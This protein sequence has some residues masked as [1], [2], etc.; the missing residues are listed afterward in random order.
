[1]TYQNIEPGVKYPEEKSNVFL[2]RLSSL[3]GA[4]CRSKRN[5]CAQPSSLE[6]QNIDTLFNEEYV[7]ADKSDGLRYIL[8]LDQINNKNY[9]FLI[10]RKLDFYQVPVAGGKNFFAGSVFDGEL[11]WTH[12]KYNTKTQLFLVFDVISYMGEKIVQTWSYF[13]RLELI[14]KIFDLEGERIE[15]PEQAVKLAKVGKL[16]CGGNEFGLCFRPKP[17]YPMC[18]LDCLIRLMPS[19]QYDTDGLIFTPVNAP[20]ETGTSRRIFKLKQKHTID[21]EYNEGTLYAGAGKN[22]RCLLDSCISFK[23]DKDF[24]SV[25][26]SAISGLPDFSHSQ[27]Y[28]VECLLSVDEDDVKLHFE[29]IRLDKVHP[30]RLGTIIATIKNARENIKPEELQNES[31]C[32]PLENNNTGTL[33][34]LAAGCLITRHGGANLAN[35]AVNDAIHGKDSWVASKIDNQSD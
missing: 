11:V 34:P 18:Q 22:K 24:L 15:S 14:R 31:R 2:D 1:M 23:L 30:N 5:P 26:S 32:R 10:N 9:S 35:V 25:C 19:L 20:V 16:I 21:L 29:G 12:T 7:V 6:R 8:Y 13:K 4:P 33:P 27:P 17:C 28:I 3:F